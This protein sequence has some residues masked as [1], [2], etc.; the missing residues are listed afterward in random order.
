MIILLVLSSLSVSASITPL[1]KSDGVWTEKRTV[2]YERGTKTFTVLWSDLNNDQIRIETGLADETVGSTAPLGDIIESHT[3]SDGVGYAGINGS[4]FAKFN[5]LQP[6]GTLVKDGKVLHIATLGTTM[7]VDADNDVDMFASEI[8]IEGNING[9]WGDEKMW[10]PWNVNH[11]YE[12]FDALMIFTPE[13]AG[14]RPPHEYTTITVDQGVITRI[15]I[16]NFDIP[17]EGFIIFTQNPATID[18]FE[19]GDPVDYRF[20]YFLEN[21]NDAVSNRKTDAFDDVRT[22]LGAGP[23]LV[24]SG[25][26]VVNPSKE[27]FTSVEILS[28]RSNRSLVGVTSGGYMAMAAVEDVTINELATIARNLG[29]VEAMSLDGAG[30]SGLYV[31]GSYTT[32][33]IREVSNALVVKHL[34]KDPIKVTLNGDPIFFDTEPYIN[35]VYNRTLVPLRKIAEALEADVG[36]EQET[37]SVLVSRYGTNLKL[38]M[39]SKTVYVN[40]VANLMELPLTIRDNRSYVPVRFITEYFGGDVAWNGATKTVELSIATT[41]GLL[42]AAD[43]FLEEGKHHD[44]LEKY[45]EA[46]ELD[47][48]DLYT[49]KKIA[50]IYSDVRNDPHNT[51]EWQQKVIDSDPDNK[52]S[53]LALAEQSAKVGMVEDSLYWYFEYTKYYY[54]EPTGYYGLGL[55]YTRHPL[56]DAELAKHYFRKALDKGLDG[57]E[58]TFAE[59]YIKNN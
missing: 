54:W 58:K 24:R 38:Q 45:L 26:K 3:D 34:Y 39:N 55:S 51:I 21:Y 37:K 52:S 53:L 41:E 28:D 49:I 33:P 44:A 2:S 4:A 30:S 18:R 8:T 59:Q 5:D 56:T 12:D 57:G 6:S 43:E 9:I 14:P 35:N 32:T 17:D 20:H 13:Y 1:T 46:H 31:N 23:M 36:W 40:G 48:N 25:V 29:L 50:Y 15:D 22:A 27:G 16:G 42:K 47:P 7:T 10:L 11:Y 19:I